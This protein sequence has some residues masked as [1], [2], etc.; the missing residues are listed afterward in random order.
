MRRKQMSKPR[1]EFMCGGKA[2]KYA[3]GG[4]IRGAGCASKGVRACK[5][6]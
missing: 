4:T 2:K 1:K 6:R 5:M 3:K